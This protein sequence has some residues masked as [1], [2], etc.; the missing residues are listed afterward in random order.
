MI[1]AYD[2]SLSLVTCLCSAEHLTRF[3]DIS[4]QIGNN[5]YTLPKESYIDYVT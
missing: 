4:I 5:V 1:C 3:P 2:N